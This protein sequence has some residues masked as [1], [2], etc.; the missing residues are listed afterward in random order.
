MKIF[1]SSILCLLTLSSLNAVPTGKE[2]GDKSVYAQLSSQQNQITEDPSLVIFENVDSISGLK[3]ETKNKLVVKED[4]LY[5]VSLAG[6]IGDKK[7]SRPGNVNLY[8]IKNNN[9]IQNTAVS[10]LVNEWHTK[11]QISAHAILSLKV[12]DIIS[13]GFSASGPGIGLV[14]IAESPNNPAIPSVILSMF[15]ID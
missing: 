11:D 13:I 14:S 15:K 6:T 4:G 12:G 10:K 9:I 5:F 8:L 1:L 7:F 2:K 3:L